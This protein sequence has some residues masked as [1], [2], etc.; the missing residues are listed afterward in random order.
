MTTGAVP[1]E[2]W[3]DI[4]TEFN[5]LRLWVLWLGRRLR[6]LYQHRT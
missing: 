3:L 1:I 2:N 4:A 5:G 6:D